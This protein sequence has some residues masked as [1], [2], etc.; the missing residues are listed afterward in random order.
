MKHSKP[1]VTVHTFH[2]RAGKNFNFP[3]A[4]D[5]KNRLKFKCDQILKKD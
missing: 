4:N 2:S 5:I 3:D 1:F